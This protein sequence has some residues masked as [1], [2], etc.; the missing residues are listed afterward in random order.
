MEQ[1]FDLILRNGKVVDGTGNPWFYSDLAISD[2]KI[3]MMGKISED[4]EAAQVID[5]EGLVVS[6]GFIDIHSHSDLSLL[7][8]GLVHGKIRQGITT[9]VIGNCGYALAPLMTEMAKK[10]VQIDLEKYDLSLTWETM[11]VNHT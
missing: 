5:A 11:D 2:G 1:L 6:P 3:V 9:E 7:V 8:D 4:M 10:D